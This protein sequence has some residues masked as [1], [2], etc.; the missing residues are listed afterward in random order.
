MTVALHIHSG[1][2]PIERLAGHFVRVDGHPLGRL[3][4]EPVTSFK[5][6]PGFHIV[7]LQ[8]GHNACAPT[9]IH[10]REGHP[11]ELVVHEEHPGAIALFAGGW[12]AL[13]PADSTA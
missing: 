13:V 3:G 8:I 5:I 4:A 10:A 2:T 7:D 1:S 6:A 9:R 11:V 12:L